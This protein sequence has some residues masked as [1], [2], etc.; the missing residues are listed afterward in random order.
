MEK[1]KR[2]FLANPVFLTT[3]GHLAMNLPLSPTHK[4]TLGCIWVDRYNFLWVGP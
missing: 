2:T 1:T 3:L 4:S